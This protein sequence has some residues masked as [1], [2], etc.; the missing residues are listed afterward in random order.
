MA[1]IEI[2]ANP[3]PRDLRWFGVLLASFA[4]VAGSLAQWRFQAPA[5]A[6]VVWT[7]GAALVALYAVAPPLR[8]WVYVGWL[9]AA[10][11]IG[12]TVLHLTLAITY[13]VVLTPIGLVLRLVRRDPLE[14]FPD[15][16]ATSYWSVRPPVHDVRRYFRQF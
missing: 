13:Y 3:T 15:R 9:Y 12:W 10:Y 11:P 8:R 5:A 2:N 7:A 1:L 6:R 4:I 16:T 14:R